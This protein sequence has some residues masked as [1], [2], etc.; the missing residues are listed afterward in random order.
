MVL[1]SALLHAVWSASIK[2]SGDPFAFNLRQKVFFLCGFA[3]L[4]PFVEWS[5]VP[6][7]TWPLVAATGVAH[8]LYFYWLSRSL[9]TTDLTVA[10]P[11]IR[12][13]PAFLPFV[14]VPLLGEQISLAGA[15]GIAI[16]VAGVWLVH[17]RGE[18]RWSALLATGTGFAYWTLLAT[19]AYSLID[20]RAMEVITGGSWSSPV[21]RSV[22]YFFLTTSANAVLFVPL[23]LRHIPRGGW[24]QAFRGEWGTALLAAIISLG[25]YGL[26]LEAY[27]SAPASYVVA[28]RQASVLFAVAIGA[29]FLRE[30]PGPAR[31]AGAVATVAGVALIALFP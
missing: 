23:A 8:G 13:T 3:V 7:A 10:Y 29:V 26:I 16:V 21:P 30:R 20:K 24:R 11:I 17:T 12:S 18:L 31:I 4:A 2:G 25:S 22:L 27:R 14:A 1:G 28:V 19:V 5:E 6:S 15:A 9:A